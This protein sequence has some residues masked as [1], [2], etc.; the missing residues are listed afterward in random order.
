MRKF[1]FNFKPSISL[2]VTIGAVVIFALMCI[3]AYN[4]GKE[5]DYGLNEFAERTYQYGEIQSE[6]IIE[7]L[8]QDVT[9]NWHRG[10]VQ[11]VKR[12]GT[13]TR[14]Y[15]KAS[16]KLSEDSHMNVTLEGTEVTINW[17]EEG[18]GLNKE[19]GKCLVIELPIDNTLYSLTINAGNSNV[20][21]DGCDSYDLSANTGYGSIQFKKIESEEVYLKTINGDVIGETCDFESLKVRSTDGQIMLNKFNVYDLDLFTGT[22]EI[23]FKGDFASLK[24]KSYSGNIT[25]GTTYKPKDINVSTTSGNIVLDLPANISFKGEYTT[26][27]GEFV[28]DFTFK[29]KG[30]N[31]LAISSEENELNLA[32]SSGNITL[33]KGEKS[34]ENQFFKKVL[35]E[36]EEE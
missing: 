8:V 18:A 30:E 16:Q 13:S 28:T 29:D 21:L 20:Y 5:S 26:V 14:I 1:K 17:N 27:S 7:S 23:N 15:E 9:V 32:T 24:A 3:S 2:F 11:I 4:V 10:E 36:D 35:G 12:A 6:K 19:L 22:G 34:V 25:A 33:N 31:I